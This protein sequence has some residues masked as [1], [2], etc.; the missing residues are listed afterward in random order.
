MSVGA[1]KEL[2]EIDDGCVLALNW[3]NHS[4]RGFIFRPFSSFSILSLLVRWFCELLSPGS[5]PSLIRSFKAA[6]E[7]VHL[8]VT[9]IELTSTVGFQ[10]SNSA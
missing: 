10:K 2:S 3:S 7:V 8:I 4:W 1:S 6:Y 9:S 5:D